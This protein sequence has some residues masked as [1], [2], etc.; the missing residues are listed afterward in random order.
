MADSES[1]ALI[2]GKRFL[3]FASA[4]FLSF[5]LLFATG[6]IGIFDFWWWMAVN[7]VVFFIWAAFWE[8]TLV[9]RVKA[10]LKTGL[11]E[12]IVLG[13][14]SAGLLYG[15]FFIGNYLIKALLPELSIQVAGI[16]AL[17][18]S[19]SSERILLL[20]GF[21]IGPGEELL[22]R[23]FF[24]ETLSRRFGYRAGY[25]SAAFLY[26]MAHLSAANPVLVLAALLGGFFWGALYMWK[27]SLVL[28]ALSHIIWD[29]SVFVW[30]PFVV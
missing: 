22:W 26:G 15:L 8:Q 23:G 13:V 11:K 10:D 29:L 17:R 4:V 30:C 12:K 6:G 14:L 1:G 20:L 7:N 28:N 16:Y 2:S 19:A 3:T 9:P 18:T 21:I 5:T 25:L 27:R 24:Q